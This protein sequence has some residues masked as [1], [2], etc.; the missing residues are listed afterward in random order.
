M[1]LENE[2]IK[3][4]IY[5]PNHLMRKPERYVKKDYTIITIILMLIFSTDI[6]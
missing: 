2:I 1:S 3:I 6:W 4:R 5:Y